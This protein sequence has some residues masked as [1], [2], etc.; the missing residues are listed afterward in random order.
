LPSAIIIALGKKAHLGTG[1]AFI[2]ECYGPDTRQRSSLCRVP[3]SAL[4]NGTGKGAHWSLLCKEP[5]HQALG[6]KAPFAECRPAC[7]A[8]G[9]AKGPNGAPFVECQTGSHSAKKLPLPS[10]TC[11]SRTLATEATMGAH[12]SFFAECQANTHSAKCSSF[13]SVIDYTRQNFCHRHLSLSRRLFY[14]EHQMTLD[15]EFV[16]CPT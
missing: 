13:P 4:N 10:A 6:K 7:S 12:W 1:K 11:G 5:I 8:K 15:K 2:V 3:S 16:E 14:D 9:L